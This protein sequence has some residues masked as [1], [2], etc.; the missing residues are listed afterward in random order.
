M[1]YIQIVSDR[2][3]EILKITDID[4]WKIWNDISEEYQEKILNAVWCTK[5]KT[6]VRIK[7]YTVTFREGYSDDV[8]F[9]GKYS[10][11]GVD[12]TR[13]LESI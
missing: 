12:V 8:C 3:T 7:D 10:I 5:C 1:Y 2:R 13:V 9:D 4:A 6:S 11:C